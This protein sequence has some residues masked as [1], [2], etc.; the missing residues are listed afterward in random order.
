MSDT[1]TVWA[2]SDIYA[3]IAKDRT[4]EL[5]NSLVTDFGCGTCLNRI[6]DT[7]FAIDVSRVEFERQV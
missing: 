4:D 6:D 5:T 1:I 2:G 7:S 3:I